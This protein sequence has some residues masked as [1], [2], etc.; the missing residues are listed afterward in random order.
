MPCLFQFAIIKVLVDFAFGAER[1]TPTGSFAFGDEHTT[2]NK[3]MEGKHLGRS[4]KMM[5]SFDA[6]LPVCSDTSKL[7]EK[8]PQS[9]IHKLSSNTGLKNATKNTQASVFT[10]HVSIPGI[11]TEAEATPWISTMLAVK[12]EPLSLAMKSALAQEH[13]VEDYVG[14]LKCDQEYDSDVDQNKVEKWFEDSGKNEEEACENLKIV[15]KYFDL[16]IKD[17]KIQEMEW[18]M[19]EE[20]I[21]KFDAD[22]DGKLN[23]AEMSKLKAALKKADEDRDGTLTDEEI[24]MLKKNAGNTAAG[25]TVASVIA[26][27]SELL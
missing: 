8:L 6:A 3:P 9:A 24:Q 12:H 26:I 16:I 18:M 10:N 15:F 11:T 17:T 13:I 23:Q 1:A 19:M 7:S 20:M 14:K 4:H 25:L 21:E 2:L 5:V 22:K 27:L